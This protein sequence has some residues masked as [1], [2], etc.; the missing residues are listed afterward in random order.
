MTDLMQYSHDACVGPLGAFNSLAKASGGADTHIY[1][2]R[3]AKAR[4]AKDSGDASS[5]PVPPSP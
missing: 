4:R 1:F 3:D 2:A 5:G